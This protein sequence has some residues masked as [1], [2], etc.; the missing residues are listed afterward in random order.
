[1]PD[2]NM[3]EDL[4]YHPETHLWVRVEGD[5]VRVGLDDMA[6]YSARAIANIR[7]KPPG[8]PIAKDRPFGTMEAGK[9]V[10]PLNLPVAAKVIE[11]NEE[12][13]TN[14]KIA[15][16]DPYNTGWLVLAE[17]ENLARD[18]PMLVHGE[19]VR[20]W[21]AKHVADWTARGIIKP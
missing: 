2:F 11:I 8:R 21:V 16:S 6:Q 1:M 15:N 5:L 9:Y 14:P 4:Y 10:G 20:D 17:P 7:L 3:P 19:A 18:L 12:V 13:I